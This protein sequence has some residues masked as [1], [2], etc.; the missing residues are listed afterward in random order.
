MPNGI[1]Y[2]GLSPEQAARV[3]ALGQQNRQQI[4][5]NLMNL[6]AQSLDERQF[7]EQ[8]RQAR[9]N[10]KL[11]KTQIALNNMFQQKKLKLQEQRNEAY[12]QSLDQQAELSEAKIGEIRANQRRAEQQLAVM[13]GM[14]RTKVQ[15]NLGE[16]NAYQFS[17]LSK[18]GVP[19]EAQESEWKKF[20]TIEAED[21]QKALWWRPDTGE[22][23]TLDFGLSPDQSKEQR[24][25]L[26]KGYD[27]IADAIGENLGADSFYGLQKSDQKVMNEMKTLGNEMLVGDKYKPEDARRAGEKA[28]RV[29][30]HYRSQVDKLTGEPEED[31]KTVTQ[32][33]KQAYKWA[34]ITSDQMDLFTPEWVVQRLVE[35]GYDEFDAAGMVK[36]AKK[37][38]IGGMT[39]G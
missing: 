3:S 37:Q 29:V 35:K 19:V 20:G 14:E 18:V 7:A 31:Q 15:T 13:E 21:G 4:T 34:P 9:V 36:D 26:K 5:Q 23:K 32:M 28:Y 6:A 27:D 12:Q 8:K 25:R 16:M 1:D 38:V 22:T 33:V 10:E 17:V 24:E 11:K 30:K 39:N 2:R